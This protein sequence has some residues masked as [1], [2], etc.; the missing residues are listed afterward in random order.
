MARKKKKDEISPVAKA[1]AAAGMAAISAMY[2]KVN[3]KKPPK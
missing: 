3:E 2:A 1:L